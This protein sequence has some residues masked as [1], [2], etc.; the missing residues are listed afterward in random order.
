VKKLLTWFENMIPNNPFPIWR[1]FFDFKK[2]S[3]LVNN[4]IIQITND[5][6]TRYKFIEKEKVIDIFWKLATLQ[7]ELDSNNCYDVFTLFIGRMLYY[8]ILKREK[9]DIKEP[10]QI[11]KEWFDYLSGRINPHVTKLSK[12]FFEILFS[13][14]PAGDITEGVSKLEMTKDMIEESDILNIL[15]NPKINVYRKIRVFKEQ[16]MSFYA[17]FLDRCKLIGDEL[18]KYEGNRKVGRYGNDPYKI[19]QLRNN[20]QY[21]PPDFIKDMIIELV[22]IRNACAHSGITVLNENEVQ[23]IDRHSNGE[24]SFNETVQIKDLIIYFIR[25]FSLDKEFENLALL[26]YI[27]G[28][29]NEINLKRTEKSK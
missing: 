20:N 14:Y 21:T 13:Y 4:S 16:Y 3:E 10:Y 22:H 27:I 12:R 19:F 15:V 6:N 11:N 2:Y 1:E 17:L 23:I 18:S 24:I 28:W 5:F 8:E 29:L 7:K 9:S 26:I 25:L